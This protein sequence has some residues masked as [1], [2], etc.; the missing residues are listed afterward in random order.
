MIKLLDSSPLGMARRGLLD[1][2]R[3][4]LNDFRR[5]KPVPREA[6]VLAGAMCVLLQI[7]PSWKSVRKLLSEA[8]IQEFLTELKPKHVEQENIRLAR[9]LLSAEAEMEAL[10]RA[11]K[12]RATKI[13]H[14]WIIAFTDPVSLAAGVADGSQ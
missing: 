5:Q 10:V 11:S 3:G 1:L 4:D 2:T 9:Q 14:R 12:E 8:S 7:K 13:L 6:I